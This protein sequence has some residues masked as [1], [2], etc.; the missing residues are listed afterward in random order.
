MAPEHQGQGIGSALIRRGIEL[1][2]DLGLPMVLLE[3][4]PAYYRR[5]GFEHS[6]R[7]GIRFDL[8]DR[9]PAEAA[10]V[11]LLTNHDPSVHGRVD[12]PPAFDV[13]G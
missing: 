11:V 6:V 12:Y 9:A 13:G 10:Q 3:G 5:F 8:P 1:A 4:S 2:E 7:H